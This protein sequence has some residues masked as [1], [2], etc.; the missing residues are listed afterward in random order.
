MIA[1]IIDKEDVAK[2]VISAIKDEGRPNKIE[3]RD[4]KDYDTPAKIFLKEK[5]RPLIPAVAV[6]YKEGVNLYEIELDDNIDIEK[7]R[8]MSLYA[9]KFKG[10]LFLVVPDILKDKV[11]SELKNHSLNAGLLYFTTA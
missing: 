8:L 6:F 11:K 10:H 9:K 1:C 2:A 7:W 5:D 4:L 3:A